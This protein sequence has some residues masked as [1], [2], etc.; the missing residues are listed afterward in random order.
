MYIGGSEEEPTGVI[1]AP[2]RDF[3]PKASLDPS[4][5]VLETCP[6]KDVFNRPQHG[7]AFKVLLN[8][9]WVLMLPL[10]IARSAIGAYTQTPETKIEVYDCSLNQWTAEAVYKTWVGNHYLKERNTKPKY[11]SHSI[12]KSN[13]SDVFRPRMSLAELKVL[14]NLLETFAREMTRRQ[15][16]FF[17]YGETVIDAYH[18]HGMAP[19]RDMINI[20]IPFSRRKSLKEAFTLNEKYSTVINIALN[21]GAFFSS[22]SKPIQNSE[23]RWPYIKLSFYGEDQ[24]Q[25]WDKNYKFTLSRRFERR[26]IFPLQRRPFWNLWLPLPK[27]T[28]ELFTNTIDVNQCTSSTVDHKTGKWIPRRFIKSVHCSFLYKKIPLV[29]RKDVKVGI[30]ETLRNESNT[31]QTILVLRD[32]S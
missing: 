9:K 28:T 24:R 15:V 30:S 6:Y 23:Y 1:R 4:V 20:A 16:T 7:L 10:V 13:T 21:E 18:H 5:V 17:L 12:I 29:F 31:L 27:G 8:I 14:H 11:R 32:L 25:I 22:S 3:G 2:N 19:W 26:R